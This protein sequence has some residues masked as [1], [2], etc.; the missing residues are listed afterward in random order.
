MELGLDPA[1]EKLLRKVA[2]REFELYDTVA[3]QS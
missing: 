2:A 3:S 1:T